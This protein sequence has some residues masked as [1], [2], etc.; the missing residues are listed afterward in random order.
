MSLTSAALTT[1][2]TVGLLAAQCK[3]LAIAS[4]AII[5]ST[6]LF[7]HFCRLMEQ[8]KVAAPRII[9]DS[10]STL[11]TGFDR[12]R[13]QVIAYVLRLYVWYISGD[14][15][16]FD[17]I[18]T[19]ETPGLGSGQVRCAICL[20]RSSVLANEAKPLIL[21]FEGGGFILGQPEDGQQHDRRLS[22]EVCRSVSRSNPLS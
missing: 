15:A 22:D 1:L 13:I 20:P 7:R 9:S 3:R 18:T 12:L 10:T 5:R 4:Q 19:V 6:E 21:V 8:S 11:I 2:R 17:R 16:D 14:G